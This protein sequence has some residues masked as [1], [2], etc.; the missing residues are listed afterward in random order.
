MKLKNIKSNLNYTEM[1]TVALDIE[2]LRFYYY[3]QLFAMRNIK[4]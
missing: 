2:T 3:L 1:L 4:H